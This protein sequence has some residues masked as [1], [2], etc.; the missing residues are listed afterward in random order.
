[1]RHAPARPSRFPAL[2][3]IVVLVAVAVIGGGCAGNT[4]KLRNAEAR[5]R[6]SAGPAAA[7]AAPTAADTGGTAPAGAADAGAGSSG[8]QPAGAADG[9][10]GG[11]GAAATAAGA[12]GSPTAPGSTG[13]SAATAGGGGAAARSAAAAPTGAP[14]SPARGAA[15]PGPS[16]GAGHGPSG[17]PSA[18][19][20]G[21]PT[22]APPSAPA[23]PGTTTGVTRD[24]VNV[25]LFYAKT[26][27]YAGLLRNAPLVMQ[28]AFDE[29]GLVNGRRLVL[30]TYDDGSYN[31]STIQVEE[32]RAQGESFGL[33]SLVSESD[34]ILAPLVEQHKVPTIVGNIDE[35]VALTS[36]HV[37][38]LMAYWA[39]QAP[40]LAEFIKNSLG[41]GNKKIGI[42]YE[43]TS[44]A[45]GAK[46]AFKAKAASLGE[47]IVFE[48]PIATDQ[49]TC[50]NEVSNMQAHGVE[51]VFLMNGPLGS[52]CMLRDARALGFK[53]IW[54]GVG[55]TWNFNATATATGGAA[56]GIRMLT[57]STTLETQKGQHF[58]ALMHQKAPNTGAEDDDLMLLYYG[59]AQGFIEG[60]RRTGPNLSRESFESTFEHNMTGYDSGYFPPPTFGPGDRTG[61]TS[62]G[63]T[64]CCVSGKWVMDQP[65]W[66]AGFPAAR[67]SA[68]D[69]GRS[70]AEGAVPHLVQPE[71]QGFADLPRS[72]EL[73]AAPRRTGAG[74]RLPAQT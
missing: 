3:S 30:K 25:G 62:V 5:A 2:R 32:K 6:V 22:P 34:T 66:H 38:S 4:I 54:T 55:T 63:V 67:A 48:Q 56:E 1:M 44:T 29:A 9:S 42:V 10:G 15:A 31:T 45:K 43:G 73:R 36:H 65:G 53:P 60:L 49:T 18:A 41:A 71:G 13:A 20:P 21:A 51:L 52:I 59:L 28:A 12:P 35:D 47:N 61:V 64:R 58:A 69:L 16:S 27:F 70:A 23:G 14:G 33:V 72:L 40:I 26:G 24:T 7:A 68:P 8:A 11:T 17:P 37:F 39:R 46:E 74:R 19:G 50:A 57:S